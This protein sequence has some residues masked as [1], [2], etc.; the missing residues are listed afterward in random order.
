MCL[1][2]GNDPF[3]ALSPL[4]RPLI[5][6]YHPSSW[7]DGQMP[8][9][10]LL[11]RDQDNWVEDATEPW[12]PLSTGWFPIAAF[13]ARIHPTSGSQLVGACPQWRLSTR[14]FQKRSTPG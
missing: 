4:D 10:T 6:C 11:L 14:P 13:T 1:N 9:P 2:V 5:A 12:T 8:Q 3:P 7:P